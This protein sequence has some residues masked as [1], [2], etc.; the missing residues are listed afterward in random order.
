MV[1]TNGTHSGSVLL[2]STNVTE[3]INGNLY[4]NIHT[5]ANPGGEIRAQL[6]Y[7]GA[8]NYVYMWSNG[9]TTAAA[10]NLNAGT[11]AVTVTDAGGCIS[12]GK[13]CY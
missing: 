13:C 1:L 4:V 2:T 6:A 5:A 9:V 12:S 3:L 7:S 11:Y 8:S 10:S